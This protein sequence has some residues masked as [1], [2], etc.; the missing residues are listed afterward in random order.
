M[1]WSH[2]ASLRLID[3]YEKAPLLWDSKHPHY[4]SKTRKQEAWEAV[5]ARINT[6]VEELKKKLNSLL[7]SFRRERM[8]HRRQVALGRGMSLLW[9]RVRHLGRF[10][11]GG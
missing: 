6:D 8:K 4:Y 2:E 9:G 10:Q 5:A 11:V 3:E 7:G 1:E